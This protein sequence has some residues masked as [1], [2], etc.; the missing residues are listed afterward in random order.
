MTG[1]GAVT[2]IGVGIE[3]TWC[4]LVEGRSA[5]RPVTR[6]DASTFRS[7]LAA[8][9]RDF[10]PHDHMDSRVARRMDRC[11][12][13]GVAAA[14]LAAHDAGLTDSC[15]CPERM[16]VSLGS[17][18]GGVAMAESQHSAFLGDGLRGVGTTLATA[19]YGGAAGSNVA[20]E[21]GARGPC[22]AQS[23][24]CASGAMGIGEGLRLIQRDE[25]DIVL[26][27]GTEAPLAPLTF[28]AF[29]LI[30]AMSTRN[31][32]PALAVRPF[33]I[34]RDGFVMAEGSAVLVLEERGHALRRDARIYA[35]V[36]GYGQSNDAY[37]MTAP[38]PDGSDAARAVRAA[39][40]DAELHPADVG[41]INAH[42][43]GTPLGDHAEARAIAH[44]LGEAARTVAVS[45]TK[46]VYGH[47]L[48]ASGA[49]E[50]AITCLA[51]ERGWMPG[52]TNLSTPDD[53]LGVNLV[54]PGGR[55]APLAAALSTSFGFGG[56]NVALAFGAHH[57]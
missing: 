30:R 24:S 49:L 2:P 14:R 27:G 56:A 38:R 50:A 11:A 39:L 17:A 26:A 23:N 25:A 6:F 3:A 13:L 18:L 42:A 47:M 12:Q 52:T 20:I 28:G 9:I 15:R 35:E 21:M 8:E 22:L 36:V 34:D 16:G 33:D 1:I 40:M 31:D 37:H 44:A 53:D 46:G 55:S 32:E 4:G 51:L 43:T 29:A 5:V 10:D 54:P 45:G 19:V 48:G 7:R 57:S 41:Y